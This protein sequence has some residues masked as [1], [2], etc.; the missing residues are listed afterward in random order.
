MNESQSNMRYYQSQHSYR[1]NQPKQSWWRRLF[2]RKKKSTI[3]TTSASR[4]ANP[5]AKVNKPRRKFPFKT[6]GFI[7]VVSSWVGLMLYVPFF[8]ITK[9]SYEGLKIIKPNEIEAVVEDYLA[10]KRFW[11]SHNYFVVGEERL[12]KVLLERF[13]MRKVTVT[14]NFPDGLHILVEEK[15]SAIIYDNGTNYYLLD[16]SGTVL[17]R[18]TLEEE[19]SEIEVSTSTPD[20]ATP[21]SMIATALTTTVSSSTTSTLE[22]PTSTPHVPDISFLNTEYEGFPVIYDAREP[23]VTEKQDNVLPEDFIEG[24]IELYSALKRNNLAIVEY[25]LLNDPNAGISLIVDKP[26]S[27]LAQPKNNPAMQVENIQII[28]KQYRPGEYIDVRFNERVYWK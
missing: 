14:K 23:A 15:I 21:T 16:Q 24:F 26:W 17:K 2:S 6:V 1:Q 27:I 4:Y 28:T 22:F 10:P 3:Q 13:S 19:G 20:Q 25:G 11:P 9:I 18:I 5:Y 8:Q 7:V 12:A